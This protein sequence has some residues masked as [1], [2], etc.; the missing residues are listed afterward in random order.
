MELQTPI[1]GPGFLNFGYVTWTERTSMMVALF[2][3][4]R[5]PRVL[6]LWVRYGIPRS[7]LDSSSESCKRETPQSVR[8]YKSPVF[9]LRSLHPS[10]PDNF[11]A[12]ITTTFWSTCWWGAGGCPFGRKVSGFDL[13]SRSVTKSRQTSMFD[14]IYYTYIHKV[15]LYYSDTE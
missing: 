14:F 4:R 11:I 5:T 10:F 3:S 1:R 13:G 6:V 2:H 9:P 7:A 12:L 8:Y 15:L